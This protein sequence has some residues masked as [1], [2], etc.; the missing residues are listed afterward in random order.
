[1]DEVTTIVDLQKAYKTAYTA[2]KGEQAWVTKV[3]AKK[4]AKKILL[5]TT[6]ANELKG[7]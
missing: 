4:D 3:I 6:L 1:M 7:K 5:E 2:A